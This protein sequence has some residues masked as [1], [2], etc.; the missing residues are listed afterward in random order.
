MRLKTIEFMDLQSLNLRYQ[1]GALDSTLIGAKQAAAAA[2]ADPNPGF[3]QS[4]VDQKLKEQGDRH[5]KE[6]QEMNE[7]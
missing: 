2:A 7:I 3:A 4:Y 1:N 6:I 5:A